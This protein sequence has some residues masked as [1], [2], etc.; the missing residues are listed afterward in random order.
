MCNDHVE[1]KLIVHDG[2]EAHDAHMNIVSG[3][4]DFQLCRVAKLFGHTRPIKVTFM[5]TASL[6]QR[7]TAE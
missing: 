1:S 5:V 3:V 7:V 2:T 4:A 6:P